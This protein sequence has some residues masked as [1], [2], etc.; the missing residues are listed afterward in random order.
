MQQGQN[1][2]MSEPRPIKIALYGA[3]GRMGKAFRS[4]L[5]AHTELRLV[6]A[7]VRP[8]SALL[9]TPVTDTDP[10]LDLSYSASLS[11]PVDVV[12]DMAGAAG[13]DESLNAA[14]ICGAAWLSA[15]TGLDCRQQTRICGASRVIA[16]MQAA[17]LSLGIAVLQRLLR[18]ALP[19]LPD[20][21]RSLME[22][23]HRGKLD[24]PSGTALQLARSIETVDGRSPP[25][26]SVRAGSLIGEHSVLLAG[27]GEHL[28]LIHRAEDRSVFARGA[29]HACRWL[30]GRAPGVYSFDQVLDPPE[31]ESGTST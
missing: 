29:V 21:D 4:L 16:V 20:W 22:R 18:V 1:A 15:S 19:A 31:P 24:A 28:E 9:G 11:E 5:V 23:H 10:Q 27:L 12:V 30:S 3:A 25:S 13:S 17:N 6:A 14:M 8:G 7:I 26:V 2:D